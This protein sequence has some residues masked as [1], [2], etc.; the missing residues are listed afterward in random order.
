MTYR[1]L[2]LRIRPN[3]RG[4]WSVHVLK[5]PAGDGAEDLILPFPAECLGEIRG[6]LA[7]TL[8]GG[9]RHVAVTE[10]LERQSAEARQLHRPE[11]IGEALFQALFPNRLRQLFER[12][13]EAACAEP[14]GG[15]RILLKIDPTCR[16][17]AH[18][19]SLPWELLRHA[20]RQDSLAL[21]RRTPVVRLVDASTPPPA[22]STASRLGV[23]VVLSDPMN[24]A[25]LDLERERRKI[26][27]AWGAQAEVTVAFLLRPT[28][29]RLREALLEGDFHVLHYMGHGAFDPSSGEGALLLNDDDGHAFSVSGPVLAQKLTDFRTD[30]R[31]VFLNACETAT[32]SG[33]Q[34]VNP[35]AGVAN[36]LLLAGLPAVVA[37][38]LPIS[39]RAAIAFSAAFYQRLASGDSIDTAVAEGRQAI[40]G[41]PSSWEWA[42]PVLFAS[43]PELSIY[44]P[45]PVP[46]P[47]KKLWRRSLAWIGAA[48][49]LAGLSLLP[50]AETE[51]SLDLEVS[52]VAFTLAESQPL[53]DRLLLTRLA[54]GD[55]EGFR[56]DTSGPGAGGWA[57]DGGRSGGSGR[58]RPLV[59]ET[60]KPA[61]SVTTPAVPASSITVGETFLDAGS[62]I[63][64]ERRG[65]GEYLL[66]LEGLVRD[67][68]LSIQ[69][70]LWVRRPPSPPQLLAFEAP[71][72]ATLT[73]R[74]DAADLHL[75]LL[76]P[77][78]EG[79]HPSLKIRELSFLEIEEWLAP[80]LEKT[81]VKEVSTVVAG[82]LVVGGEGGA[83]RHVGTR[84][85]L[86]LHNP[87]GI[88]TVALHDDRIEA[89]F[90]GRVTGL[91][92]QPEGAAAANL[93]PS[94]LRALG[95][96]IWGLTS[97]LAALAGFTDRLPR[98]LQQRR[99]P[100]LRRH[101]RR[102][103][104]PTT[105]ARLE[106]SRR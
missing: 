54:V 89:R 88:L 11:V 42:T 19:H 55:L 7:R 56:L 61:G 23:L 75:A 24:T 3:R 71:A 53:V 40:H 16:D 68:P 5:C 9:T 20:E 29:A 51:V 101:D 73:P 50:A 62:R 46:G 4:G 66:A 41:G 70:A 44:Q 84:E 85:I 60:R 64:L 78:G 58:G 13:L 32:F 104:D 72:P 1:D 25:R 14:G 36:A 65:E 43:A 26:T 48:A 86:R 95:P 21:N 106:Y 67:I 105:R 35:F 6:D 2:E 22:P 38:Q 34:A 10:D 17:T 80:D 69:G 39:D 102:M 63:V 28:L 77:Y 81:S 33:S 18:L 79:L 97:A 98:L 82:S 83:S 103:S 100:A 31:L 15:L 37:M 96:A 91:T 49:I 76:P 8:R 12:S 30:L 52:R 94:R 99:F 90:R 47:R 74:R 45:T 59:L 87:R 92:S 57:K 27:Q 93:M